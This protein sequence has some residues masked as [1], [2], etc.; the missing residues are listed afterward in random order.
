MLAVCRRVLPGNWCP[1]RRGA[2]ARIA[3]WGPLTPFC[4]L[5][6]GGIAMWDL[7]V[8]A[9]SHL[10]VITVFAGVVFS[11]GYI[12]ARRGSVRLAPNLLPAKPGTHSLPMA[13]WWR[14]W[15]RVTRCGCWRN[16]WC[17]V[18]G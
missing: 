9:L 6:M 18:G 3:W 15:S 17:V 8:F 2:S 1:A 5:F 16:S 14:V 4:S 11:L 12:T 10:G 7:L 13:G